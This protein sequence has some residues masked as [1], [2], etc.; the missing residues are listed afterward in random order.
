MY[1]FYKCIYIKNLR[2]EDGVDIDIDIDIT[3]KTLCICVN[4]KDKTK[5]IIFSKRKFSLFKYLLHS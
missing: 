2:S 1:V 5:N 4:E 3:I